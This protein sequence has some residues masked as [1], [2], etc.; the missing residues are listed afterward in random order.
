MNIA[1]QAINDFEET[2][3]AGASVMGWFK[4]WNNKAE[5]SVE[6]WMCIAPNLIFSDGSAIAIE[7]LQLSS[8]PTEVREVSIE[9]AYAPVDEDEIF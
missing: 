2:R 7:H 6:D 9:E 4:R 3:D 1:Q 5:E 8:L